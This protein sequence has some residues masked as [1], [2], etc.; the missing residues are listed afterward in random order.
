MSRDTFNAL[1]SELVVPAGPW[2]QCLSC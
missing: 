2:V 1:E